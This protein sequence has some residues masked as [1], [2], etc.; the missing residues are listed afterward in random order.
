MSTHYFL[1]EQL[2]RL[3]E[4]RAILT[5]PEAQHLIRVLRAK[6]G[7]EEL[8]GEKIMRTHRVCLGN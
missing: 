7:D 4:G 3:T 5:G 2:E 6:L 1:S 8:F